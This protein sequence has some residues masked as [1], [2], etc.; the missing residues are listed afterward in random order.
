MGDVRDQRV[1]G[2]PS[3]HRIDRAHGC[4]V[5]RI[6]GEA[7][8]RLRRQADE[9]PACERARGVAVGAGAGGDDHAPPLNVASAVR[10]PL[11]PWRGRRD[12]PAMSETTTITSG[13]GV[14]EPLDTDTKTKSVGERVREELRFFGRP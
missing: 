9:P 6:G 5:G 4:P 13:E 8:H 10:N 1:G 14:S 3:L 7:V 11:D 2:G 12:K